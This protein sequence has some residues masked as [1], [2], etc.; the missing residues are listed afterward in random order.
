METRYVAYYRVSTS[1]QGES[2]LGLAAQERTVKQFCVSNDGS[3]LG[4]F[5]EIES[6]TKKDRPALTQAIAFCEKHCATLLIAKLDRLARNVHFVSGLLESGVRFVAADM[7][8]A[9][10]FMMHVYAA[11][12]EEEARRISERTRN[13]LAAAKARGVQ[14]GKHGKRLAAR[15]QKEAEAFAAKY[16]RQIIQLRSDRSM[17]YRAIADYLNETQAIPNQRGGRWHANSVHRLHK[18]YEKLVSG[19]ANGGL[20]RYRQATAQ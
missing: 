17:S 7:P 14:L 5:R 9:D 13:A 12:A 19:A 11:V 18:R 15:N 4:E 1:R 6:G 10:R 20:H 8:N 2:G 16:G 3:V